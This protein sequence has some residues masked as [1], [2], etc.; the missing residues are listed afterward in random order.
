MWPFFHRL[1]E[2]ALRLRGRAVHFIDQHDLREERAAVE[3]EA[4]LVP[5]EDRI[6]KDV[7]RQEIAR[8][9]DPLKAET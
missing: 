5:I 2:R 9:L 6:A 3:R 8:E 4:L 7:R 1:E